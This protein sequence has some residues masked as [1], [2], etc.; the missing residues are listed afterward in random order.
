M[1]GFSILGG[2]IIGGSTVLSLVLGIFGGPLSASTCYV[3]VSCAIAQL[4]RFAFALCC[5]VPL[6]C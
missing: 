5:I 3:R 2:F 6:S 1:R 4:L